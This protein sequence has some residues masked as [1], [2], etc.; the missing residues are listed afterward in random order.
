MNQYANHS[1]QGTS[2]WTLENQKW[3]RSS[4]SC[5]FLR[6]DTG[7]FCAWIFLLALSGALC[8]F[9]QD[10]KPALT[11]KPPNNTTA[12]DCNKCHLCGM[13]SVQD[14]CLRNPC[15]RNGRQKDLVDWGPDIVILDEMEREFVPVP[16]NHKGHARMAEMGQGCSFCHHFSTA[17]KPPPSCNSCHDPNVEGTDPHMPGLKGAYHQQCLNCHREWIDETDCEV[18][19]C[20]KSDR[21]DA[22]GSS[23]FPTTDEVLKRMHPPIRQP[24]GEL[25]RGY[26][27]TGNGQVIFRH[28]Q[29]VQRF[30][31]ACV[32]CHHEPSC[33]KCHTAG[34]E[35]HASRTL[36][37][38]HRP[39][40]RC[41]DKYMD[42]AAE[43]TG[44]CDLCHWSGA[45][46]KPGPFD[47]ANVGWALGRFHDKIS[48]RLCHRGVPFGHLDKR[49]E[50]CHSDWNPST[51]DHAI[52]GQML[53]DRH[54]SVECADC[55]SDRRFERPPVCRACHDQNDDGIAFPARRPGPMVSQS[56]GTR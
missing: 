39:C 30:G 48:C 25:Y 49:C 21:A 55:H 31:L 26:P 20:L 43:G 38:H 8:G 15:T 41:H 1:K 13:P 19:H 3:R 52:T 51:F 11:T 40:I 29:H 35:S 28:Q 10:S 34:A 36:A 18:C 9:T 7:T 44:L 24:D 42:P 16:F 23:V 53:D 27:D 50:G 14:R 56:S 47:H 5:M 12:A 4:S 45:R 54:K 37:D 33:A 6:K 17:G 22:D 2:V 32:E 46:P